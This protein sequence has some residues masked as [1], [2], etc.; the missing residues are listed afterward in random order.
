MTMYNTMSR[1]SACG[2][3][4]ACLLVFLVNSAVAAPSINQAS[5][6]F[7]H[8][9]T[10]TITGA[11]FGTKATAAP[12]VWDD[13][14]TG[15]LLTDN[16]KWSD[17]WPNRGSDLS[18]ITQYHTPMRGIALPHN[19]ITRYI[20]GAHGLSEGPDAGYNVMFWK[21]INLTSY[22]FTF[23]VSW[24]QMIDPA[25]SPLRSDWNIKT[26]DWSYGGS[27]YTM[28]S[29][30]R[31]NWYVAY[32]P[33]GVPFT[34][35]TSDAQYTLNDD[36]WGFSGCAGSLQNPDASG[37]SG[38]WWNSGKN[39]L[40]GWMKMEMEIRITN[41]SSGYI[42]MW[43]DGQ[44]KINYAGRTDAWDLG[45]RNIGIGGYSRD[46]GPNNW[47]YFADVY[48][49]Y[50]SQ[51]VL[52]ANNSTLANAT[53]IENQIP[54]SWSDSSV[55]VSVNLGKFTPG[56]T[57]Y[58]FVVDATGQPNSTGFPVKIG[59]GGTQQIASPTGLTIINPSNQ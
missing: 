5:G 35:S 39:F 52:L 4:A 55:S 46:R 17:A 56:Q 12:V 7:N 14:S 58:L 54:T 45:N 10:A 59:S 32:A 57:A 20:A 29:C 23:Y 26:F 25:A 50:T 22:P 42:K 19:H 8:K 33:T 44:Q 28:D 34:T 9:D 47:R 21:T 41:Q 13:A 6:T 11:G 27:P 18:Y 31:N 3:T 1:T 48:L 40:Y 37:N 36:S 38:V 2:S 51:R 15:T 49:D 43:E 16:G 53:V 24:Y 30:S